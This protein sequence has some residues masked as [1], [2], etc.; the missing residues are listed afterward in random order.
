VAARAFATLGCGGSLTNTQEDGG[1]SPAGLAKKQWTHAMAPDTR[2]PALL[3]LTNLSAAP[4]QMEAP[5]RAPAAGTDGRTG[6]QLIR[7]VRRT[8]RN[9]LVK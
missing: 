9:A 3:A 5:P 8:T 1:G 2:D 4:G 7:S 6:S